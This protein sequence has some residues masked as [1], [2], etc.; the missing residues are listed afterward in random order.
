MKKL[1]V[2]FKALSDKMSFIINNLELQETVRQGMNIENREE[3]FKSME[4][5]LKGIVDG[6]NTFR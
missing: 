4:R 1:K 5:V 6:K 2:K 3:I